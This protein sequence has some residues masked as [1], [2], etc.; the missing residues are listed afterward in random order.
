MASPMNRARIPLLRTALAAVAVAVLG[1]SVGARPP[2]LSTAGAAALTQRLD[3]ATRR[4]DVPA[5]V[6]LVT[7][8]DDVMFEHAAGRRDVSNNAPLSENAIFRIASMGKPVTSAAIMMLMESG[9]LGLDDPA[10]R[11]LPSI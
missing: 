5:V 9:R 4:G 10:N 6:V 1:A 2:A 7:N 11:Y 8:A 3:A